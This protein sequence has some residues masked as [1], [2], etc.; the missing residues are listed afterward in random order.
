[1][2]IT[3]LGH[4]YES[5]FIADFIYDGTG[6]YGWLNFLD[7]FPASTQK[8]VLVSSASVPDI[9][10]VGDVSNHGLQLQFGSSNNFSVEIP[11]SYSCQINA[12]LEWLVYPPEFY[13]HAINFIF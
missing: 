7:M 13:W 6:A 10:F 9:S 3:A 12:L 1:M 8:F 11:S 2:D 4:H 5:A